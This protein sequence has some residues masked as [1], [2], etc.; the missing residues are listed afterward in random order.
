MPRRRRCRAL[1]ARRNRPGASAR[2]A[3]RRRRETA[4]PRREV[5]PYAAAA[6]ATRRSASGSRSSCAASS[7]WI[8][9][10]TVVSPPSMT[11]SSCSRKSGFP[12]APARIAERLSS[13]SSVSAA[14]SASSTRAWSGGSASRRIDDA[15]SRPPAHAGRVS[16]SSVGRGR[17]AGSALARARRHARRGRGTRRAQCKSSSTRTSGRSRASVSSSRRAAQ[18]VSSTGPVAGASPA[19]AAIIAA[20]SSP[21]RSP[22]RTPVAHDPMV[23]P[24]R[25]ERASRSG[26]YVE[27]WPCA[28]VRPT[29]QVATADSRPLLGQARLADTRRAEHRH[30]ARS[31]VTGCAPEARDDLGE[32]L[33]APDEWRL[34]AAD[35]GFGVVQHPERRGRR[36]AA[37]C[38][39]VTDEAP[40]S[41]HR[42]ARRLAG[43]G[44]QPI[45]LLERRA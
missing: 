34:E 3:R 6:W 41:A 22:A 16:R 7:A 38:D 45:G 37:H 30:E 33:L 26:A 9:S 40:R 11:R 27:A 32:L 8:E 44:A 10:G 23:P 14:S 4:A 1:P 42:R 18:A 2:G 13:S 15:F 12:A 25:A 36:L 31:V 5:C 43:G 39:C 17:A 28:G 20:T 29:R 24:A 19:A 21:S 35:D